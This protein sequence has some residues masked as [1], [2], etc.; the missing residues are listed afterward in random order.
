LGGWGVYT[1]IT[2][3]SLRKYF[4][5]K[6]SSNVL[7]ERVNNQLPGGLNNSK[8]RFQEYNWYSIIFFGFIS[9]YFL[10]FI[11]FK[12]NFLFGY[13]ITG[14]A[15]GIFMS[16]GGL[17]SGHEIVHGASFNNQKVAKLWGYL[18]ADIIAGVSSR[19]WANKHNL[20]HHE[21]TNIKNEGD[22][23]D[24]DV[25][26][27]ET[28][29]KMI[30]GKK[31]R[32]AIVPFLFFFSFIGWVYFLD[33]YRIAFLKDFVTKNK[34][35]LSTS[36]RLFSVLTKLIHGSIF[37]LLPVYIF[38]T[39]NGLLFSSLFYFIEA[40]FLFMSFI[41]A[42]INED[43]TFFNDFNSI[44]NSHSWEEVQILSSANFSMENRILTKILGGLNYQIE[45]H[46]FPQINPCY[47]PEISNI[48]Q[49][50]CKENNIKYV[51]YSNWTQAIASVI[52]FILN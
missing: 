46:L 5:K 50:W 25:P 19:N 47:Y 48:V 30:A 3:E 51:K 16:M 18:F 36:D 26:E 27:I 21:N 1:M 15:L 7:L 10:S 32:L 43:V 34:S 20:Y 31:Y 45:H 13:L 35:F 33:V 4:I 42:H 28:L 40:N 41:V 6:E 23:A 17:S 29:K 8:A 37:I 24:G 38:G 39:M 9:C 14:A 2:N 52:K 49:Q 44:K 11:F 22:W 12:E